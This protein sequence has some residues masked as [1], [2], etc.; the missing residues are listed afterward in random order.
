MKLSTLH[1]LI[2]TIA[3]VCL[4]ESAAQSLLAE[5]V[6]SAEAF[7]ESIESNR[8]WP[9]YR[10]Y[11]ASGYLDDAHLP[12][13]FNIES[14]YNVKWNGKNELGHVIPTGVYFYTITSKNFN[15]SKKMIIVR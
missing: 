3:L 11:Y 4:N 2:I 15:K 9:S 5:E 14:S 12:D 7:F 10:G 13:S 6:N 1:Y 8:Q